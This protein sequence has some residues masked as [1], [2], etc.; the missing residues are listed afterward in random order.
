[1]SRIIIALAIFCLAVAIGMLALRSNSPSPSTAENPLP[2]PFAASNAPPNNAPGTAGEPVVIQQRVPGAAP[3]ASNGIT[4]NGTPVL[5]PERPMYAPTPQQVVAH[6][7]TTRPEQVIVEK[8]VVYVRPRN[9]LH[10]GRTLY[11][12]A[13]HIFNLPNRLWGP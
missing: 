9:R 4:S 10:I 3:L 6:E 8:R 13:H 11:D 7:V 12:T 1:M 5:V 2:P